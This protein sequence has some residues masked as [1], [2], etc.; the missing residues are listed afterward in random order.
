[1]VLITLVLLLVGVFIVVLLGREKLTLRAVAVVVG[2]IIITYMTQFDSRYDMIMLAEVDPM[3]N[4]TPSHT[5]VTLSELDIVLTS[6]ID[7]MAPK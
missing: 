4:I 3:E 2:A 1:M 7:G 5:V 6:P